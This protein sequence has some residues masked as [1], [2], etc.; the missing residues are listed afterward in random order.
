A[1]RASS[2]KE[3][4]CDEPSAAQD[5][6]QHRLKR[7]VGRR[8]RQTDPAARTKPPQAL[9]PIRDCLLVHP[10]FA[11]RNRHPLPL[12]R[13]DAFQVD[14]TLPRTPRVGRILNLQT[15]D[16]VPME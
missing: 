5:I 12:Q 8:V 11:R 10:R 6:L 2:A 16:V 1:T 14:V 15:I 3:T 9:M 4:S 7:R 13:L